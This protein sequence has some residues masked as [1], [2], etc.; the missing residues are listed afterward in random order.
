MIQGGFLHTVGKKNLRQLTKSEATA[1]EMLKFKVLSKLGPEIEITRKAV[2]DILNT[3]DMDIMCKTAY[4]CLEDKFKRVHER[5]PN[6]EEVREIQCS[7][8]ALSRIGEEDGDY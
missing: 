1:Y 6:I 4:I 2:A 3:P 5:N 8:Y 7:A